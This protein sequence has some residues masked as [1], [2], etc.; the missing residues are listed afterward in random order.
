[1]HRSNTSD[2]GVTLSGAAA[3]ATD[4]TAAAAAAAAAAV[5]Y[6]TVAVHVEQSRQLV[7]QVDIA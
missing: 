4:T 7:M 6:I 3:A 2:E 1:M 5:S